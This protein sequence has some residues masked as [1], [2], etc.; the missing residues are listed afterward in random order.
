MFCLSIYII[1]RPVLDVVN[2]FRF[3]SLNC[4]SFLE[5]DILFNVD[6]GRVQRVQ[7][8]TK[9]RLRYQVMGLLFIITTRPQFQPEF[10]RLG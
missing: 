6:L 7:G 10:I 1:G 3:P 9:I 2:L 8:F 4:E 5:Q